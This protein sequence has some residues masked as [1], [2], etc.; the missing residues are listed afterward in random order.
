MKRM[1]TVHNFYNKRTLTLSCIGVCLLFFL[2]T[3]L[4]ALFPACGKKGPPFLPE[5]RIE[6]KVDRLNG[7]WVDGRIRLEGTVKDGDK[8]GNITGCRV[9]YASYPE[10]QPPCE[11]CPIEMAE[12][13][14]NV[15]ATVSEG[16]FTCDIPIAKKEGIWFLEVR[17]TD[18]RGAVGPPS[19]RVKVTI[20]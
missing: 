2:S 15:E 11:G 19:E 5:K 1:L 16:R 10:D 20:D 8:G 17:L 13:A 9:Y 4:M 14:D 3:I 18:S 7:K 12:F 6:A